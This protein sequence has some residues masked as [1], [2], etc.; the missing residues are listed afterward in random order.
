MQVIKAKELGFCMGVR[1]AVDMM[2]E[3]E[4]DLGPITSLGSTVHNP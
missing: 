4:G 2:E 1:R 3:A